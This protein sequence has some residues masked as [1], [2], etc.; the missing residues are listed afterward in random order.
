M[1]I[2]ARKNI[3]GHHIFDIHNL[4]KQIETWNPKTYKHN[5]LILITTEAQGAI[6][7]TTITRIT[8]KAM[9]P[10]SYHPSLI[11]CK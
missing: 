10:P 5:A 6:P 3:I 1:A 8:A 4:Q 11:P 9:L 7:V 2:S